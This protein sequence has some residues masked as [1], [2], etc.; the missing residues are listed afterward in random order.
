MLGPMVSWLDHA[1]PL[2]FWTAFVAFVA[3]NGLAAVLFFTRRSR[4]AVNRWT[5]PL[6]AV[7]LL[8]LG[9][10]AAIPATMYATRVALASF[11]SSVPAIVTVAD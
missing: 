2:V 7:N 4:D 6:L 11:T 9:A 10:G 1:I 5:A 3:I 8:L